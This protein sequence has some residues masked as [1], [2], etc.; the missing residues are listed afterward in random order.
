MITTGLPVTV[1]MFQWLSQYAAD[2]PH[3]FDRGHDDHRLIQQLFDKPLTDFTDPYQQGIVHDYLR[4]L[5]VLVASF[6]G[7]IFSVDI[8]SFMDRGNAVSIT[9]ANGITQ[10]IS[11]TGWDRPTRNALD[12]I[13]KRSCSMADFQDD[14]PNALVII[15][16]YLAH[17]ET[18]L[19]DHVAFSTAASG[20]VELAMSK[21]PASAFLILSAVPVAQLQQFYVGFAALLPEDLSFDGLGE[22]MPAHLFFAK[23]V[24]AETLVID[25]VKMHYNL[26]FH[27][28]IDGALLTELSAYTKAFI[29]NLSSDQSLWAS[30]QNELTC[31]LNDQL[32][33]RQSF[34][35]LL[36]DLFWSN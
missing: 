9:W 13:L 16:S 35:S 15:G 7:G 19:R 2:R 36:L 1:A 20:S 24:L 32:L 28:K 6:N 4:W 25:K 34:L 29:L 5:G 8:T 33:P 21:D 14:V 23:P 22:P 30:V 18:Q 10:T 27:A 26:M 31:I 17:F 11:M 12:Y 3:W